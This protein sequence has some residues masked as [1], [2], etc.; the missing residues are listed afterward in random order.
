MIRTGDT[1][2]C[3]EW[4]DDIGS[5]VWIYGDVIEDD[6]YG[7]I[8]VLWD[9]MHVATWHMDNEPHIIKHQPK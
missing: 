7:S 6:G 5:H 9:D 8:K 2:K 4:D 1:V 3:Y